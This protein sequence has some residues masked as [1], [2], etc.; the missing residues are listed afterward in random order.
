LIFIIVFAVWLI[1]NGKITAEICVIG[2]IL[3]AA[4]YWFSLRF[5]P[6]VA[7]KK[8]NWKRLPRYLQYLVVL[9]VE[10]V[11]ANVQVLG[12]VL[13]GR[14]DFEPCLIWF[15]TDLKETS[16]QV[17]LANSITLTPGTITVSLEDGRYC[18]HCLDKSL[19]EG[20]EDSVFVQLLRRIEEV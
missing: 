4:L 7:G 2:L 12:M 3:S 14:T 1:L 8:H 15:D 16:S 20:I 5:I 18:V 11:K 19:G 6:G 10:I 13:S 17:M 9:L